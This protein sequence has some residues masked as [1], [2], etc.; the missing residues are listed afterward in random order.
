MSQYILYLCNH[1]KYHVNH[2]KYRRMDVKCTVDPN[3]KEKCILRAIAQNS[4]YHYFIF[5]EI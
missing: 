4:K 1:H 2:K 5:K 3:R